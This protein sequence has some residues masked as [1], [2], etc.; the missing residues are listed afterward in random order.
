MHVVVNGAQLDVKTA[1]TIRELAD[2]LG[3]EGPI[4]VEVNKALVTR[5]RHTEYALDD[6]DK[7]EIVQFVGGG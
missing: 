4:A 7:V 3:L 1:I 5:S 6:G 2:Q